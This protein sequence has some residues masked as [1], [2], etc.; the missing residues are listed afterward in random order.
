[1]K[2]QKISCPIAIQFLFR[3]NSQSSP[4]PVQSIESTYRTHHAVVIVG[5]I[6]VL[7][8]VLYHLSHHYRAYLSYPLPYYH[9]SLNLSFSQHKYRC[10]VSLFLHETVTLTLVESITPI[11]LSHHH[12]DQQ[13]IMQL[14]VCKCSSVVRSVAY[15]YNVVYYVM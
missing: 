11:Y 15:E 8:L 10:N 3:N 6:A 4:D 2:D 14:T 5:I 9:L 12:T 7:V 1:M 13:L